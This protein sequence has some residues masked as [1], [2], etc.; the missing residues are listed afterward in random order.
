MALSYNL[1]YQESISV[2]PTRRQN[3]AGKVY[4]IFPNIWEWVIQCKHSLINTQTYV[5]VHKASVGLSFWSER[6]G[7]KMIFADCSNE[8]LTGVLWPWP[9]YTLDLVRSSDERAAS[10]YSFQIHIDK[11]KHRK[12]CECCPGHY[13]IVYHYSSMNVIVQVSQFVSNSKLCHQVT[14]SLNCSQSKSKSLQ[15]L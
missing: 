1:G 14:N 4:S 9:P 11:F 12:N 6:A 8:P 2:H 3:F 15:S 7:E 5:K 13:L 10:Q